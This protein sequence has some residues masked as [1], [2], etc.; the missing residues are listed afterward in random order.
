MF[1]RNRSAL[2][3]AQLWH[4]DLGAA[5]ILACGG[6]GMDSFGQVSAAGQ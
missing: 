1:S 2:L 6:E 4:K 5:G 3:T